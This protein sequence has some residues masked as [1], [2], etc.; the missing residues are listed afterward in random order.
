LYDAYDVF[1][2]DAFCENDVVHAANAFPFYNDVDACVTRAFRDDVVRRCDN[3]L[4][5]YDGGSFHRLPAAP[6]PLLKT[7]SV[8]IQVQVIFS[9]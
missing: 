6:K 1:H 9:W 7:E 3:L 2:D 8:R 4:R 5:F